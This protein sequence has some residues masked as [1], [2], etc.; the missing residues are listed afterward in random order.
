MDQQKEPAADESLVNVPELSDEQDE[1]L[2]DWLERYY[3]L[4]DP[5]EMADSLKTFLKD[6]PELSCHL[7][8][9]T[10]ALLAINEPFIKEGHYS[11]YIDELLFLRNNYP[12]VY[13]HV[14]GYLDRDII[15]YL[16]MMQ[17]TEKIADYLDLFRKYPDRDPDNLECLL[18]FFMCQGMFER[19]YQLAQ[20]V[21]RALDHDPDIELSIV[22]Q[23]L[24]MGCFAPYLEAAV[25]GERTEVT[26]RQLMHCLKPYRKYLPEKWFKTGYH[27]FLVN[28]ILSYQETKWTLEGCHN[29]DEVLEQ[30]NEM[31]IGFM[32]YLGREKNVHWAVADYFR[33]LLSDFF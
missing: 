26:T 11:E 23:V 8:T 6:H 25:R 13:I 16:C 33:S 22:F 29:R 19:S 21:Y 14:F 15:S 28:E 4:S 27:K 30:Y 3:S 7:A 1:L 2:S 10:E 31:L 32:G 24:T 5:K 17:E 18:N 12:K 9:E 20:D